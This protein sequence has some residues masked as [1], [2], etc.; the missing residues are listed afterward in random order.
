MGTTG[1]RYAFDDG[2]LNASLVRQSGFDFIG[3]LVS[4]F[5]AGNLVLRLNASYIDK[6]ETSYTTG[7]LFTNLVNTY[8]SP[9]KWRSRATASWV[10]KGWEASSAVNFVGSYVNT[11]AVGNPSVSSWTTIDLGARLNVEAYLSGPEWKGVTIAA[12]VLNVL[13]RNPPYVNS[14]STLAQINYDPSNASPLGRFV[15]VELR[16]KW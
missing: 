3:S 8:G 11:S 14:S 15:S 1:V 5:A 16:K 10:T 2:I 13:D 6:I 7:S 4:P 12:N 9:T